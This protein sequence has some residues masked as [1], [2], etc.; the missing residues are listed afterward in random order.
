[1]RQPRLDFEP[2][3]LKRQP[4]RKRQPA[5]T[6]KPAPAAAERALVET[7]WLQQCGLCGYRQTLMGET[8]LCDHC[9]G[10]IVRDETGE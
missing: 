8:A 5:P 1:M 2:E 10:I 7:P 9:G 4:R 6:A 3:E